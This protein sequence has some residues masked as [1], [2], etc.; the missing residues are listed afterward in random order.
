[1]M[2]F[3]NIKNAG[4]QPHEVV[5]QKLDWNHHHRIS[6]D[7]R[8]DTILGCDLVFNFPTVKELA[9]TT[10]YMLAPEGTFVHICPDGRESLAYL[11]QFLV[12]A[13]LMDTNIGFLKLQTHEYKF[14]VLNHRRV[15]RNVERTRASGSSC[16][17]FLF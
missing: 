15:G 9:R 8:F 13:Y 3:Y 10:A 12:R 16:P 5:L 17:R 1:M 7:V 6:D 2:A 14:Q 4:L 11:R